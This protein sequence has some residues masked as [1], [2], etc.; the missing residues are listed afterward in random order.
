MN[1]TNE[2]LNKSLNYD[3]DFKN[4][5]E[6]SVSYYDIDQEDLMSDDEFDELTEMLK[7]KFNV[8]QTEE[9]NFISGVLNNGIQQIDGSIKIFD[10]SN[11]V[12]TSQISLKKIKDSGSKTISDVKK[13]L[14]LGV[15]NQSV[16][17]LFI[18][19]KLDGISLKLKFK[20]DKNPLLI[21]TRGGQDVTE[22]LKS[23]LDILNLIKRNDNGEFNTPVLHGELVI[24]KKVFKEKYSEEYE[25]PRN[26]IVGVLKT[27]PNDLRFIVCTDGF[28]PGNINFNIWNALTP[29]INFQNYFIEKYKNDHFPY[30]V[31]GMVVGHKLSKL[32]DFEVK[33]NYPLN[34]V[35]LKFKAES[36]QT[37]VIDIEWSIK[38]SGKLTPVL[39]VRPV[40]LDG[41]T[42]A[43][44]SAYSYYTLKSKKIGIG[45]IITIHK[46]GDIIP[47]VDRVLSRSVS[48]NLPDV[49]F[50]EE[51]KHIYTIENTIE[52]QIQKFILGLKLL[53]LDGIGPVISEKIGKLVEY[54]IVRLFDSNFRPD[55][56][57][58]LGSDSANWS[59]FDQFYNIK[60]I[61]LD[62]LIEM[63]QLN[64]CG[65]T[66]SKKFADIMTG[67]H[68]DTKGINK[69]LLNDTCKAGGVNNTKIKES[70]S[71]LKD[72]GIKVIKPIEISEDSFSFEM[73]GDFK[74]MSKNDFVIE[75][76]KSKPN[77]VH[78]TLNKNTNY[79]I[80]DD[81]NTNTSKANKARK[82]N[83][84]IITY[85]EALKL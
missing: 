53:Q 85:D 7:E 39:H 27:N 26:C 82:Y 38:K 61:P 14:S 65:K 70:M 36:V 67:K 52:Q 17:Q 50:R 34:M 23:N 5:Y 30:Q 3:N 43:K 35:A 31:D 13:F 47:T 15:Y 19:P 49:D 48:W 18:G 29:G 42:V 22:N 59:R 16:N 55:I 8:P 58:L 32:S 83:V 6:A 24:D 33:G 72:Y 57:I 74:K 56:K 54:D 20:T 41:T 71:K 64:N 66:L 73:S 76:K 68:I 2:M 40:Q 80:V 21:Q 81:L 78:S 1:N 60:T 84:K 9:A 62:Q 12:N 11:N 25:N 4:W 75:L 45:S 46:S 44:A 51:G 69:L 37:E 63:L 28:Q 10:D 77:W 79:L